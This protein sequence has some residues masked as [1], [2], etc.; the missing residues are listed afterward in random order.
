MLVKLCKL[1]SH[2]YIFFS[3][4]VLKKNLKH[5]H[6]HTYF[7]TY[8]KLLIAIIIFI[9]DFL[10]RLNKQPPHDKL[11]DSHKIVIILLLELTVLQ[12]IKL[13]K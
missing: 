4:Q 2:R 1:D 6:A 13:I 10:N 12:K 3:L 7:Q 8:N 5:R 9:I 11:W